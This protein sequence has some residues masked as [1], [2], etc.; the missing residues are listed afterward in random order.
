MP[1]RGG[2]PARPRGVGDKPM[3]GEIVGVVADLH[4]EVQ[5][6]HRMKYTD[7]SPAGVV[8]AIDEMTGILL[9]RSPVERSRLLGIGIGMGGHVNGTTGVVVESPF[10]GWHNVPLRQLLVDKMNLPVV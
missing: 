5:S 8:A 1:P 10:L 9:E 3:D 2:G 6:A 7:T 4:A